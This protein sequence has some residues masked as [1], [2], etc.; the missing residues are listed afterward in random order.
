MGSVRASLLAFVCCT[1]LLLIARGNGGAR[2]E[3]APS[4][5]VK[6]D[7]NPIILDVVFN[8]ESYGPLVLYQRKDGTVLARLADIEKWRLK[9]LSIEAAVIDN[10]SYLPLSAFSGLTYNVDPARQVIEI[11]APPE[12]LTPVQLQAGGRIGFTDPTQTAFGTFFNYDALVQQ[13]QRTTNVAGFLETGI[14]DYWGLVLNT[15]R[16]GNAPG[17]DNI[18]RFDTSY[19]WDRP[20]HAARLSVGD[21]LAPGGYVGRTLRFAG[22]S[23]GTNFGLQPDLTTFPTPFFQ[24]QAA[25]PSTVQIYVND[26]L[27]YTRDVDRGPFTINQIPVVTGNGNLRFVLKDSL[28]VERVFNAPYYADSSNLRAGLTSYSFNVGFLRKNYGLHSFDYG[29]AFGSV[30]YRYGLSDA[31]TVEGHAEGHE[32]AQMASARVAW[33]VPRV[34]QIGVNAAGSSG[35]LGQGGLG[36]FSFRR[37]DE[38]WNVFLDYQIASRNF[39]QVGVDLPLERIW[40]QVGAGVGVSLGLPGNVSG[41]YAKIDYRG[42]LRTDVFSASHNVQIGSRLLLT[43]FALFSR[44]V[45]AKTATTFGVG[46]SIPLGQTASASVRADHQ[47]G[48][49]SGIVD[50]RANP[51][52]DE[53]FGYGV[54]AGLGSN[55]FGS[56]DVTWRNVYSTV[57]GQFDYRS[58][59]A[60]GQVEVRGSVGFVETHPFAAREITDA[61]GMVI[62]PDFN[63]VTVFQENRPVTHTNADGMAI[64]PELN[65]YQNNKI[66]IDSDKLPISAQLSAGSLSVV[67]RYRSAV[68]ADFPLKNLR[69]ASITLLRSD[70]EPVAAGSKVHIDGSTA[71]TF[72]GFRGQVFLEDLH[73]SLTLTVDDEGGPCTAR[74]T[75]VPANETLPQLPP[76]TCERAR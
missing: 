56:A 13:I 57:R 25:L 73:D 4:T 14:S 40:R 16:V 11:T 6:I 10:D 59:A 36:G 67:P 15:F 32:D 18:V 34:G 45:G 66:S 71:T 1:P 65:S 19:I 31:I 60:A 61:Y 42:G 26:V 17:L 76:V 23:Y 72:A 22:L 64:L 46:L 44:A 24:G 27:T 43:S 75:S 21:T 39:N 5:L 54:S 12:L 62:L 33:L 28:G 2:A 48:Q 8:E 68:I 52:T 53:G 20:S 69:S 63:D 49:T 9:P 58:G 70:G 7:G 47:S 3:D 55:D 74:I 37:D 41:T 38:W 50:Y 35:K 29:K 51:P 30:T